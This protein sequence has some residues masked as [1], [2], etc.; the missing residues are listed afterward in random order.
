M[1]R[2]DSLTS[3]L[4]NLTMYD[5]KSMYNQAKNVVL[6]VSEMEAKVREATNDEPWGASSTLMQDI[7]QGTF[8]FQNFNE[9]M[10]CIYA[11]FMEKEARQWRQIYKALQLLEYLVKH[12]S[13]RVVDDARSHVSTLKMLRN[14]HY[15]DDKGKDEGINVRNR[16]R[17]L[18][19]LLSDVE[20]IRTERRKAK[21]N[22]H[23]YT[24]TGNDAMSFSS[25]GS[26]YGGFGNDTLGGGGGGSYGDRMSGGG[27][28]REYGGSYSG[29]G[30]SGFRDSVGR[31]DFEEYSAGDDETTTRRSNSLSQ[32]PRSSTSRNTPLRT[33]STP[34]APPPKAKEPEVDLLGGFDDEPLSTGVS[35]LATNKA[36]PSLQSAATTEVDDDF[37]D[38][39]AAP[40]SPAAPAPAP[41]PAAKATLRE[42]LSP[43]PP[44]YTR[45]VVSPTAP[46][47]SSQQPLQAAKPASPP[48][49]GNQSF[50]IMSPTANRQSFSSPM[51]PTQNKPFNASQPLSPTGSVQSRFSA[52]PA[53]A[54]A[55]ANSNFDDLWTMSLG[56]PTAST[57]NKSGAGRSMKDL[58]KEKVQAGIWGSA[59]RS[60]H[61]ATGS[62][63]GNFGGVTGG[64]ASGNN[65][66][67]SK[68]SG[69]GL[70]D[71]L[72]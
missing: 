51:A 61:S 57:N 16:A 30:G 9:I 17:E 4:S 33:S 52:A 59:Q 44:I 2:F 42:M 3:T 45:T 50:G 65:S 19:E 49:Y 60:S 70:D 68:A 15:I 6:N 54:P 5:I 12:G 34:T 62:I 26:R 63:Y 28:D 53:P 8:N 13:E 58:E 47:F 35:N 22:R 32:A 66:G 64:A 27:F 41:A 20:S 56:S 55:K 25:G 18:V 46:I 21:A 31:R 7:A 23:K 38:F 10:P 1:D 37:D 69:G 24:G 43:S 39:Q 36:L 11:R 67:T 71:L 40:M 29:G 48:A 14:F 72:L